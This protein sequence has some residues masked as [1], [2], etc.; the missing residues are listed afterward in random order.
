LA[1]LEVGRADAGLKFQVCGSAMEPPLARALS[2][3]VTDG[4]L[5]PVRPS[6]IFLRM[7]LKV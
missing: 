4:D 5:P 3:V 1:Q 6:P 7:A 2:P